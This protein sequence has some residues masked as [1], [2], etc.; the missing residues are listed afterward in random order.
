MKKPFFLLLLAA[1]VPIGTARADEKPVLEVCFLLTENTYAVE[2]S[3]D[4][5]KEVERGAASSL[6]DK[7]AERVSFLAPR[8]TRSGDCTKDS[9]DAWLL[10]AELN[11]KDPKARGDLQEVGFH[12]SL[13]GPDA[14]ETKTVYWL[15]R[16][17]SQMYAVDYKPTAAFIQQISEAID[18]ADFGPLVSELLSQMPISKTA[19]LYKDDTFHVVGWELAGFTHEDLCMNE[20]S[21]LVVEGEFVSATPPRVLKIYTS[22]IRPGGDKWWSLRIRSEVSP[23]K[24]EESLRQALQGMTNQDVHILAVFVDKYV[25]L[26]QCVTTPSTPLNSGL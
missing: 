19:T 20:S 13:A 10:K 12:L 24:N 9:A 7:L 23:Q 21:E 11:R 15:F 18:G 26:R 4:S 1:L 5:K 2:F 22:V 3:A 25:Q 14:D 8:P 16:E 6:A 17:M